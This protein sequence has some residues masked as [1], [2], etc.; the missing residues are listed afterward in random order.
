MEN[1]IKWIQSKLNYKNKNKM[2]NEP[3]AA[4]AAAAAAIN[5][6]E[7]HVKVLSFY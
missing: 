1:E 6:T 5:Q 2:E 7:I 3:N 4:A